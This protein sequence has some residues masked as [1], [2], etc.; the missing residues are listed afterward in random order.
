MKINKI[1]VVAAPAFPRTSVTGDGR[2]TAGGVEADGKRARTK[3]KWPEQLLINGVRVNATLPI[4]R[5][6]LHLTN[7]LLLLRLQQPTP[8]C[9]SSLL[10]GAVLSPLALLVPLSTLANKATPIKLY[11]GDLLLQGSCSCSCRLA[12]NVHVVFST[13]R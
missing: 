5:C 3:S 13:D 2:A 1:E 8:A 6:I 12:A 4:I 11:T 10:Y 7:L 9:S